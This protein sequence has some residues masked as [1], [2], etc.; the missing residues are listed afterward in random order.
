MINKLLQAKD[1]LPEQVPIG[2][3]FC[4]NSEMLYWEPAFPMTENQ[5]VTHVY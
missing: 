5:Q 3:Q 4:L 2:G 1:Q